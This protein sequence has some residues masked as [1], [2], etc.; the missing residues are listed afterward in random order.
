MAP[1]PQPT[2]TREQQQALAKARARARISTGGGLGATNPMVAQGQAAQREWRDAGA[3]QAPQDNSVRMAAPADPLAKRSIEPQKASPFAVSQSSYDEMDATPQ[4]SVVGEAPQWASE[5]PLMGGRTIQDEGR[6]ALQSAGTKF[7]VNTS[8]TQ[9]DNRH[10]ADGP[11]LVGGIGDLLKAGNF[12]VRDWWK[13]SSYKDK[14]NLAASL[15]TEPTGAPAIA[16]LMDHVGQKTGNDALR[17]KTGYYQ[18]DANYDPVAELEMYLLNA[19]SWST[20]N[21][22]GGAINP[23][24]QAAKIGPQLPGMRQA[25]AKPAL[26]EFATPA[27]D[28]ATNLTMGLSDLTASGVRG[29]VGLAK[30]LRPKPTAEVPPVGGP[31]A[32]AGTQTGTPPPQPQPGPAPQS[33]PVAQAPIPQAAPRPAQAGPSGAGQ[34]AAA[35]PVLNA[36]PVAAGQSP[37]AMAKSDARIIGRLLKAGGVARNDVNNLLAGL[38]QAYQGSNSSRLPLA[39]FA[40]EYLPTVLPKQT[41]DDVIQKLRGFGRER[42]SANGPKD[43]SRSTMRNTVDTLRSTQQDNLSGVMDANLYKGKLIGQ[44]DKLNAQLE[45]NARTA[46]T[47][48]LENANNRLLNGKATQAERDALGEIQALLHNGAFLKEVPAHLRIKAMRDGINLEDYVQKDPIAA[49]HWLQS[50]LR[51]AVTAAEGVGGMATSES[52]LYGEMRTTLLEQLEKVVPGY[53]GAR[54]AHGDIYGAKE[55]IEFG[56]NFF[57]SARSEVETA[58]LARQFKAMSVRQKTAATMSIRDALKNEFRNKAEDTAAKVTRLQQAGVLDA[59][60]TV[61]GADGKRVAEAIRNTVKENERLRAVDQLSGSPTH[62]NTVTAEA[63]QKAVRSPLNTAIK[64]T[65]DKSNLLYTAGIDAMLMGGGLPPFATAGALV[66]RAADKFG[67]PGAKQL[68]SVT[69]T[70]YD[71]PAQPN[72]LSGPPKPPKV[73]GPRAPKPPPEQIQATLDDLLNQYSALDH[74][75]NPAAGQKLLRQIE[76]LKKQLPTPNALSPPPRPPVKNGF[77]SSSLDMSEPARMQRAEP[78]KVD[79]PMAG[80]AGHEEAARGTSRGYRTLERNPTASTLNRLARE[81]SRVN[82]NSMATK[83]PA[84]V[85]FRWIK[86]VDGNV[87]IGDANTNL[88]DTMI[89]GLRKVG[90]NMPE[91]RGDAW[92]RVNAETDPGMNAGG[93]L[94]YDTA[95][96]KWEIQSSD[97]AWTPFDPSQSGSSKLLAGMGASPEGLGAAAGGA[98][99]YVLNPTDANGD[100]VIDD[101]DRGLN[102][103]GGLISGGLGVKA[104]RSGAGAVR[105]AMIPQ[106]RA[107]ELPPLTLPKENRVFAPGKPDDLGFI[108]SA[109]YVLA[110]PIARFKDAKNLTP[111]QWRKFMR[112]GGAS[113]EAFKFQIEPALKRLADEGYT[114]DIPKVKLEEALART[115]GTLSKPPPTTMLERMEPQKGRFEAPSETDYSEYTAP[116]KSTN[117]QQHVLILPQ[118]QGQGYLSHNWRSKNPVGHVRTTNR[119]SANGEKVLHVEELQSDL[120]QEGAKHGYRAD[121]ADIAKKASRHQEVFRAAEARYNEWRQALPN[122]A[123]QTTPSAQFL[124]GRW[125]EIRDPV[126]RELARTVKHTFEQMERAAKEWHSISPPPAPM[127]NWEEPFIRYALKQGADQG[128][129]VITFPSSKTLHAS[130]QNEGTA[131]FYDERLPRHLE[132]VAK[133]LGLSVERVELPRASQYS[134]SKLHDHGSGMWGIAKENGGWLRDPSGAFNVKEFRSKADAEAFAQTLNDRWMAP[135]IRLTPQAKQRLSQGIIMDAKDPGRMASPP[136]PKPTQAGFLPSGSGKPGAKPPANALAGPISPRVLE[137]AGRAAKRLPTEVRNKLS[138]NA[139]SENPAPAMQA[140]GFSPD[141]F[142][143]AQDARTPAPG[144]VE[145]AFNRLTRQPS[146]N[147][148]EMGLRK[149]IE[150]VA[151]QRG[152]SALRVGDESVPDLP[153]GMRM[154]MGERNATR[155]EQSLARRAYTSAEKKNKLDTP[156]VQRVVAAE[157]E[158]RMAQDILDQARLD[159]FSTEDV[160]AIVREQ[161]DAIA[162][163]MNRAP[164][165]TLG[166]PTKGQQVSDALDNVVFGAPPKGL[167]SRPKANDATYSISEANDAA[168]LLFSRE[169]ANIWDDIVS[170][171]TPVESIKPGSKQHLVLTVA[172]VGGLGALGISSAVLAD[173]S[174]PM[175]EPEYPKPEDPRVYFKW[176][177]QRRDPR[178]IENLQLRLNQIDPRYQ[179][180]EDGQWVEGG[181]T[182]KVIKFWQDQN[183]F[184][185]DGNL[186]E[187]QAAMIEAQAIDALRSEPAGA[188]SGLPKRQGSTAQRPAL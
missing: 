21:A 141:L 106:A 33:A 3:P 43:T 11:D 151:G 6:E 159:A 153:F 163:A 99:G 65:A 48:A 104:V 40:E 42:Y 185:P 171:R 154:A 101:A 64:N 72:A 62:D 8:G 167:R 170:G 114:G 177:E 157:R 94:R 181:N 125:D 82:P 28:V 152:R 131:K 93:M 57:K 168:K 13:N 73:S 47:T 182:D 84:D 188:R 116:G 133:S 110:N 88:H 71:L 113:A 129:D 98:A 90:V 184:T 108:T 50:E 36:S 137:D 19:G 186:T 96:G 148:L 15:I 139:L 24:A 69:K 107:P 34:G 97:F 61:L 86:D 68:S 176:D 38:V 135:A 18:T 87:Y 174:G 126:G 123:Q 146:A 59:L 162:K 103:M 160:G 75:A 161:M 66:G 81:A 158:A 58:R 166:L 173:R 5:A 16:R 117:Y 27:A 127:K 39:F 121:T 20:R 147:A 175:K 76:R 51:Q 119:T 111:E 56:G 109:E 22:A 150:S 136:P 26:S 89:E 10:N 14:E 112:E 142:S 155:K 67:N 30:D 132:S 80:Y 41:A 180:R 115:R 79:I 91:G 179:L 49:A 95:T 130:L 124:P 178:F 29:A 144:P 140:S 145:N 23:R 120:H 63:A 9:L 4:R 172:A 7:R 122:E 165:S 118:N 92:R 25:L 169:Y 164:P 105:N 85:K 31:N 46:Y 78:G 52:R 2:L 35:Q 1:T 44:E 134:V 17:D 74:R 100:G 143:F 149:S 77:G 45:Q 12:A 128:V 32:R 55:A 102:A 138:A 53:R 60:E 70:L 37:V 54:K 156:K 183:D 187:E 83:P